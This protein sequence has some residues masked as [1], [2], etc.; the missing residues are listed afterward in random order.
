MCHY[1]LDTQY[2]LFKSEVLEYL[3][4]CISFIFL[5]GTAKSLSIII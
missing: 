3:L 2:I 1:F 5:R 4:F